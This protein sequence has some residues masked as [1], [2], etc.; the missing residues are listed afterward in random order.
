M[1][2][3]TNLLA[4]A[5]ASPKRERDAAPRSTKRDD[6]IRALMAKTAF[7][8]GPVHSIGEGLAKVGQMALM[9]HLES[10]DARR[11]Q[12]ERTASADALGLATEGQRL[13]AVLSG[14]GPTNIVPAG[15]SFVDKVVSV[16][17]GGDPYAK[18]PNS[19]ATGPGQFIESTW[20]ETIGEHRPDLAE[21]RSR[22][23]ILALRTDPA[24]SREMTSAYGNQNAQYLESRGLPVNEG[25]TYLA[26]FAGPR[27]AASILRA[28]PETPIEQ[29]M[30]PEAIMANPFLRGMT[31][32]DVQNWAASKMGGTTQTA[33]RS[34]A[35]NVLDAD[36]ATPIDAIVGRDMVE[37]NPFLQG[38]T[39]GEV[40]NL[41]P[42]FMGADRQSPDGSVIE[43][44]GIRVGEPQR[45]SPVAPETRER[46]IG[47]EVPVQPQTPMSA[48]VQ[49]P[50]PSAVPEPPVAAEAPN[51]RQALGPHVGGAGGSYLD[52]ARQYGQTGQ[53]PDMRGMTQQGGPSAPPPPRPE[54]IAPG[55]APQAAPVAAA[56]EP[57][58]QQAAQ[59]RTPA[60]VVEQGFALLEGIPRDEQLMLRHMVVT[61]QVS[62]PEAIDYLQKRQEAMR[63]DYAYEKMDDGTL[64]QIDK[65]TG[66]AQPIYEGGQKPTGTMQEYEA[67]KQQGYQGSFFDYQRDLKQAG[68]S[69]TVGAPQAGYRYEYDERGNPVQAVPIPGSP[70]AMEAEA[71]QQQAI[72]RDQQKDRYN[73]IVISNLDTAINRLTNSNMP[74]AGVGSW[75]ADIPGTPQRDL[76]GNLATI[77]ANI[78]FDRLQEMREMSPTGGALGQVSN[79]E[80]QLLQ[81]TRGNLEQSQSREQL[82]NNAV[83]LRNQYLD[84]IH[85]T[86]EEIA[87][88]VRQGLVSPEQAAKLSE[89][90]PLPFDD[91]GN[92]IGEQSAQPEQD[93]APG[94]TAINPQTGERIRW[95]GS[96][97][98]RVQ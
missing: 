38:M 41:V 59:P 75:A 86:P 54:T 24:I 57:S 74:L 73:D 81:A 97:W 5:L 20:L 30:A 76:A 13:G 69:K 82:L 29:I 68:T 10:R 78:G 52:M 93:I 53:L 70:A 89:R 6:L 95:N 28:A 31:A 22:D 16:E 67:A 94:T 40:Q 9:G 21:G 77:K 65:R 71:A 58:G 14:D 79:L 3:N 50:Q 96:D 72:M 62:M 48:P 32:G 39:A 90:T 55:T 92:P 87:E 43:P 26:H 98:E 7:S 42:Q 25:S 85:G 15:G 61:G 1:A 84:T 37:A 27:G 34:P 88:L 91:F 47:Q 49:P 23:D 12:A 66:Q 51:L 11:E 18:N 44:A 64:V 56:P 60:Q 36:P 4:M 45:L 19:S 35:E 63:P 33:K 83:M 2:R 80:N 46:V 17:S 8:G